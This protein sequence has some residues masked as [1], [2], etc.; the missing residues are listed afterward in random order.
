MFS[1]GISVLDNIVYVALDVLKA[2]LQKF[3]VLSIKISRHFPYFLQICTFK[4]R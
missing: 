2:K 4:R 3:I 1:F